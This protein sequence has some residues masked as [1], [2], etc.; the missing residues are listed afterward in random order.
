[1]AFRI[2]PKMD[3]RATSSPRFMMASSMRPCWAR[4]KMESGVANA[5]LQLGERKLEKFGGGTCVWVGGHAC[6]FVW[7]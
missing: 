7:V 4:A 1:M 5:G 6:V 3:S 2:R